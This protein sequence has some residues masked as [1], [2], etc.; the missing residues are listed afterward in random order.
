MR[1]FPGPFWS[2]QMLKYKEKTLP[3]P[4]DPC[5]PSPSLPLEIDPLNTA[6]VSG[7]VL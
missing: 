5:P 4:P 2:P 6:R 3:S 7:R 1:N